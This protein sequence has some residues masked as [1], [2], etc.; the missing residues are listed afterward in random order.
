MLA[1]IAG[2]GDLPRAVLG[3]R[4]DIVVC[5]MQGFAPDLPVDVTFRIEQ[6]GAF[7]D[8]LTARG[9]RKVCFA[10]A[11]RRPV[12]DPS[13]VGPDTAP[14]MAIIIDA[15]SKGDDGAL[16]AIIG[17]FEDRGLT[18][19]GA[20]TLAPE[21][22]PV[23]SVPTRAKPRSTMMQA[24]VLGERVIARLGAQDQG[25][26][27]VVGPAAVLAEEGPDGTDAML[28]S[29][30]PAKG[31]FLYK[32]PKPDQDRRADLP[33]IGLGTA[34][35][36]AK[37]GLDGIIIEAGGVMVLDLQAVVAELD[38]HG[39]ALWVRPRTEG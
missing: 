7:L 11:V 37:A 13:L 12:I 16:R 6:L 32:A 31:G 1:L 18:V 30:A 26:A 3:L 27:C 15:I 8:D 19:V 39:M 2:T 24:A 36:A 4:R 22:L 34:Q 29:T 28:A 35:A 17:I 5:A 33:V 20:H 25:Q 10:G 9:V 21:L 38:D 14:L 23:A